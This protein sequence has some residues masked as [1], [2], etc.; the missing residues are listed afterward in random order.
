MSVARNILLN[1]I[2]I[3]FY[4]TNHVAAKIFGL[5]FGAE[6]LTDIIVFVLGVCLFFARIILPYAW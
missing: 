5:V 2:N 4:G 3:S 6:L 1:T